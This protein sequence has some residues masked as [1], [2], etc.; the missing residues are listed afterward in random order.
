[1]RHDNACLTHRAMVSSVHTHPLR[2]QRCASKLLLSPVLAFKI[3]CH[4]NLDEKVEN[5]VTAVKAMHFSRALFAP[6]LTGPMCR[7]YRAQSKLLH[8]AIISGRSVSR[9]CG[10]P[11]AGERGSLNR[12]TK[13][14]SLRP[15]CRSCLFRSVLDLL[16]GHLQHEG[17][18]G[19]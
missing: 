15:G 16:T 11:A 13:A 19:V 10:Q 2:L 17:S 1:M 9:W 12:R 4:F 7:M 3:R 18:S 6:S 8:A 14:V 5:A